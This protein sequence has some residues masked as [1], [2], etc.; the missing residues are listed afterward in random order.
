[1][2][3]LIATHLMEESINDVLSFL[4]R[5][6]VSARTRIVKDK[7]ESEGLFGFARVID[8]YLTVSRFMSN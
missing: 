5:H 1:M 8:A 2:W 7:R 3:P 6:G 4:H